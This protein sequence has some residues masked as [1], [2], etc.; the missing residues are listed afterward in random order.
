[1]K[2]KCIDTSAKLIKRNVE[3]FLT[4]GKVYEVLGQT[5]YD[6]FIISDDRNKKATYKRSRFILL[7]LHRETLLDQILK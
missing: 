2:V 4:E 5:D 6:T 3:G 1:M 7:D